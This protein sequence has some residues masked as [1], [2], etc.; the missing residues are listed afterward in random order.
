MIL[1]VFIFEHLNKT[2]LIDIEIVLFAYALKIGERIWDFFWLNHSFCL[3]T[4]IM[5][6]KNTYLNSLSA[7][8]FVILYFFLLFMQVLYTN[9]HCKEVFLTWQSHFQ[10]SIIEA[11]NSRLSTLNIPEMDIY[12][13]YEEGDRECIIYKF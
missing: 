8:F 4:H 9:V 3:F 7:I 13:A 2:R 5:S 12:N 1:R 10:F 6:Y 11:L